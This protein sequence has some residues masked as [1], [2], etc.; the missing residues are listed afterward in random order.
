MLPTALLTRALALAARA[1]S[2]H[3][4]QPWLVH[5]EGHSLL[6][7]ADPTRHLAHGD[8]R[9]RDLSLALGGFLEAL[10][11]A[12][13]AEGVRAQ[14]AEPAPGSVAALA[15]SGEVP[16]DGESASLLRR[17]CTSR[18]PYGPRE[19]GGAALA[20]LAVAASAHGLRLHV[21]ARG[22][23]EHARWTEGFAAACREGWLD[24]QAVAELRRWVRFDPEG[25]RPCEDGLSTHCLELPA[26]A[27]LALRGLLQPGL[28]RAL[29]ALWLAP[30]LAARLAQA[31]AA[32]VER[33]PL[34]ACLIRDVQAPVHTVHGAAHAELLGAGAGVLAVWLE[35][36]RQGLAVHPLS[37][38]LD[39]RGWALARGLG[40][41]ATCPVFVFRLGHS[42]PPARSGRL[43]VPRFSR[44]A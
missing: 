14:A 22:S 42:A 30:L 29:D 8:P 25:A 37:P 15:L 12:L 11:R 24:G 1:P 9:R 4:T 19:P 20:A 44:L 40:V 10:R 17:R 13:A 31:E 6:L 18:L 33:T 21:V 28:W 3:N 5:R 16:R 27:G 7:Q 34:L 26:E 32:L 36:T 2:A 35:A 43:G 41:D 23:A 39:R 38:L